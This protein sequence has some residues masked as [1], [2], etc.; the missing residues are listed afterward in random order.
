MNKKYLALFFIIIVIFMILFFM[1]N[2]K[3][4]P[5]QTK[6]TTK[7]SLQKNFESA[8][9]LI[10][11]KDKHYTALLA[12]KAGTIEIALFAD[13]TPITVNNFVYL[14]EKKFYNN[15]IFHRIIKGFMIQGG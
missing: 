15:T 7:E 14:A 6:T 5:L 1:P 4:A 3:T 12:T 13:K 2:K 9:P 8:P 10:I 11:D